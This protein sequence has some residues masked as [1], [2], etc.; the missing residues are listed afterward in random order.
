MSGMHRH[1]G[2]ADQVTAEGQM[3]SASFLWCARQLE[4]GDWG[5]TTV[6]GQILRISQAGSA[7]SQHAFVARASLVATTTAGCGLAG[8]EENTKSPRCRTVK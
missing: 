4:G 3:P 2:S 1:G 8:R 5:V 7:T 6:A